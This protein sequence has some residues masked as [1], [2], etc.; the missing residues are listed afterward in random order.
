MPPQADETGAG[1][2]RR[3]PTPLI[4]IAILLLIARVILGV[5][6]KSIQ[7]PAASPFHVQGSFSSGTHPAAPG[8]SQAPGS[9]EAV[10]LV[11]WHPIAAGDAE[12]QASGKPIL[13]DFTAA[14]CG[15]CRMLNRT[16]F[17][18]P[19]GAE[20]INASFVP[21]RVLDRAR[22]DGHNPPEVEALQERYHITAFPTLVMVAAKG[23]EPVVIEGFAG[24]EQ[25]FAALADAAAKL[26]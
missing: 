5:T 12:A 3:D 19:R 17:A 11:D 9:E 20:M 18:D 13:Y 6:D 25:T 24:R 7:A 1:S 23:G 14:W 16:V 8:A 21:V 10:D 4:A 26:K 15:P 22:E 2:T